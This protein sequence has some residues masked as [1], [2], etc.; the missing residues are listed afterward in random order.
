MVGALFRREAANPGPSI[1]VSSDAADALGMLAGAPAALEIVALK[2]EELAEPAA[3]DPVEFPPAPTDVADAGTPA[4]APATGVE[5]IAATAA[6][7]IDKAE[8]KA[9]DAVAAAADGAGGAADAA[10]GM[11][12]AAAAADPSAGKKCPFWRKKKCEAERA[13]AA[14]APMDG[15][16]AADGAVAPD[17]AAGAIA[18]APLADAPA[19]D[20]AVPA[21]TASAGALKRAYVQIGIFSVEANAQRAADQ[22]KGAGMMATVKPDEAQGK[23]F[24][25]VI[26]GPAASVAER[27]AL[28]GRVKGIG[29]PDAYPVT[30]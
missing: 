6:A 2:R 26:V 9:P 19:A 17:A 5:P 12:V 3:A 15:G 11:T 10:G 4:D 7:A 22:M 13:A 27:D 24:W 21:T 20:A 8:G 1:Q 28:A 25:R 23:K 30:R 29:Y 16:V 14:G 18:T